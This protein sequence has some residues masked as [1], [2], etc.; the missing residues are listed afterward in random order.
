MI[1]K[2]FRAIFGTLVGL[3][4]GAGLYILMVVLS[5]IANPLTN[6]VTGKNETFQIGLNHD[7]NLFVYLVLTIISLLAS[8]TFQWIDYMVSHENRR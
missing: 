5:P 6:F 3:I 2:V 4:L 8:W 7:F 1:E